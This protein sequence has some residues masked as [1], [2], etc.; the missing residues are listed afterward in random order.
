MSGGEK[1]ESTLTKGP[2]IATVQLALP[3]GRASDT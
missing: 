3:H 2:D 1:D